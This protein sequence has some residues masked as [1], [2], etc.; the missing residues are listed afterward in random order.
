MGLGAKMKDINTD[1]IF[2]H[3]SNSTFFEF[4][5]SLLL[6]YGWLVYLF[7]FISY[8]SIISGGRRF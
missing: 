3:H 4:S 8:L 1:K 6:E 5:L 2:L 7:I